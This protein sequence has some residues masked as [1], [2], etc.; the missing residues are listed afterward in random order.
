MKRHS[1]VWLLAFLIACVTLPV[2]VRPSAAMNCISVI[3]AQITGFNDTV[4][5]T[6]GNLTDQ[7]KSY[8]FIHKGT[9]QPPWVLMPYLDGTTFNG[10]P[11]IALEVQSTGSPLPT[12]DDGTDK[13]N[14]TVAKFPVTEDRYYGFAMKLGNFG[15]PTAE[16]MVAQWWQ[17]VPYSPPLSLH[18]I[19]GSGFQ[20]ELQVRNNNT[21]GNPNAASIEIP[22]GVCTPGVWHTFVIYTRPNYVGQGGTGEVTVWHNNMTTPVADW[23]GNVGYIPNQDVLVNGNGAPQGGTASANWTVYFGPYREHQQVNHQ[24]YWANIRFASTK[25]GA[26][27]NQ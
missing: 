9:P 1:I 15:D 4:D 24:T 25:E 16:I 12:T 3:Y 10:Y 22:I 20:C 13:A 27:P 11:A 8:A 21:G 7:G 14:I 19:P 23:T 26:N 2:A 18:I 5:P 17:G 6:T